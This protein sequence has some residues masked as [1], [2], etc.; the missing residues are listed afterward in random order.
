MRWLPIAILALAACAGAVAGA[1]PESV[2]VRGQPS[3]PLCTS[4]LMGLTVVFI[5]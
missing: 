5:P 2:T 4:F 3:M 1:P